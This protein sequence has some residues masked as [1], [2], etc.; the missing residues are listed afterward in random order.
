MRLYSKKDTRF[1]EFVLVV[2]F[3]LFGEQL[4]GGFD[5]IGSLIAWLLIIGGI[6]FLFVS[7]KV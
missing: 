7:A 3:M 1:T 5:L 4:T 6:T 2:A